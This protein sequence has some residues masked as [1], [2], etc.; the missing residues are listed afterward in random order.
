LQHKIFISYA[1]EDEDIKERLVSHLNSLESDFIVF[2]SDN[3]LRPG[4]DFE[5]EIQ[6]QITSAS[7]AIWIIS[8]DFLR[9]EFI[10]RVERPACEAKEKQGEFQIFTL[11]AGPV[12]QKGNSRIL[13]RQLWHNAAPLK[14]RTATERESDIAEFV[15]IVAEALITAPISDCSVPETIEA[16]ESTKKETL[17][18]S[19]IK[20]MSFDVLAIDSQLLS[21]FGS[22]SFDA[23]WF[24]TVTGLP[25]NE[26]KRVII[27]HICYLI[28]PGSTDDSMSL[29]LIKM[30]G[31]DSPLFDDETRVTTF[32]R[33]ITIARSFYSP[34]IKI[35]PTGV[36]TGTQI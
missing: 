15:S 35:L 24:N 6:N 20:P 32:D 1:R 26:F 14:N 10:R 18:Q 13:R 21:I 3:H 33:I 27:D 23:T 36:L 4:D 22:I 28:R 7:A 19:G 2:W 31:N 9:S 11:L 17:Y 5:N 25:P 8:A 12:S 34:H 29:L 30:S 16:G